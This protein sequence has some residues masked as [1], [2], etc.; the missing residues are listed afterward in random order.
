MKGENK[1]WEQFERLV[2]AIHGAIDPS[3]HVKWNDVIDGRQFDVTIRFRKG[4]YDY[5]TVIECKDYATAVTVDKVE[6]FVTKA[7]DARANQVVMASSS[8]FQSGAEKV[9]RRHSVV[10]VVLSD[11]PEVDLSRFG[12]T[13]GPEVDAM[14]V[15]QIE[16]QY[17][18]GGKKSLP[19]EHNAMRYYAERIRVNS[20]TAG[21]SLAQLI[22]D[23]VQH[24]ANGP[25]DVYVDLSIP[26]SAGAALSTPDDGE[27]PAK[28][29]ASVRVRVAKTRTRTLV[30][31]VMFDPILL[32][33]DVNV[34]NLS[35]GET[36]TVSRHGLPLG[37]A[38]KFEIGGFY[39]QPQLSN[40]YYCDNISGDLA[41]LYL[42]ESF[43]L[44][45]LLQAEITVKTRYVGFYSPVTDD[46]I[47]SRL[48]RRLTKMK[49]RAPSR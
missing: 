36:T 1:K 30:G 8:G 4:L 23:N 25:N 19:P 16:L 44:G 48:R 5:L 37:T 17:I 9:A 24:L 28:G 21:L 31:P 46:V 18:D 2:A 14:H 47:V 11:S 43:Q 29:L 49:T 38:L 13:W 27:Y 20:T 12:A 22:S 32:L 3:A 39:D 10:L 41:T 7:R 34:H 40:Y 26:V 35:S 42:V 33:A 6:A 45:G 15:E